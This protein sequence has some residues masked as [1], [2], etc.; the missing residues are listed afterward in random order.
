M[1]RGIDSETID[2]IATDPPF[3][4][5]RDFHATPDSLAAGARFADRWRWEE[6][7]QPEW[8][9]Q[10]ED[11]WPAVKAVVDAAKIASGMDTAAFL[12]W[13]GVRVIEMRRVLK[14][15]GSIYLHCDD[16]AAAWIKALMDAVF[17]RAQFQADLIWNRAAENLSRR[18]YRRASEHLLFYS[19]SKDYTWNGAYL[20]HSEEYVAQSY[21]WSDDRGRYTTTACQN[22]ADRPNMVYEFRGNTRQ[23]RYSKETMERL[24]ADGLLVFNKQGIP[25]RKLYLDDSPGV[26]VTTVWSDINVLQSRASERV[27]YPTQKPLALYERIVA[28]SSN[29]GDMVLDPFAGCATT[30]IAAERLGRRWVAMDLWQGAHAIIKD[31]LQRE[32]RLDEDGD[33]EVLLETSPPV[34]TDGGAEAAPFLRRLERAEPPPDGTPRSR[35]GMLELLIEQYGARCQGCEREFDDPRYLQLDHNTPRVDGGINHVSNRVLLCGPCNREKGARYTL[36]GLRERN[37]RMGYMKKAAR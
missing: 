28:A 37:A 17:G 33:Y 13:L 3:N 20:P 23:W 32:V 8:L 9:D 31:R 15:T 1:L 34:R 18:K 26:A 11:D 29:E 2:L 30:P 21:R 12:C 16:T 10:I 25:R 36:T 4:K 14:P 22:N 5:G 27:G 6:D 24:D 19:K 7:L 35:A